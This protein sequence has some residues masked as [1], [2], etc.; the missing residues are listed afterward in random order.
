MERG[1][2]VS[3]SADK[4][5]RGRAWWIVWRVLVHGLVWPRYIIFTLNLNSSYRPPQITATYTECAHD[6]V[7]RCVTSRLNEQVALC[8]SNISN[9]VYGIPYCISRS[10][11]G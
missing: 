3:A 11:I 4:M 10:V 5:L 2:N 6:T 7:T 1:K 8:E 9:N